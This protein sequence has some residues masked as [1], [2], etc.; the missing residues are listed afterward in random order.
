MNEYSDEDLLA[1]W[2]EFFESSGLRFKLIEV[3]DHF[4]EER[5]VYVP[6]LDLDLFDPDFADYLMQHPLKV[7]TLGKQAAKKALP[8]G[9][10]GV[11]IE[12]RIKTLPK[13]SKI[14]IRKIRSEHLGK[15]IAVEGLVRK[16]TEVR[17]KITDALFQCARCGMIIREAQEGMV[18]KE[19]ME[20]YKEQNGCGR[21]ASS[22]KFK[23]LSEESRYIDT[24]KI[25]IQENPEGL[26]GGAQPE[27][28][29]GF[30]ED[31][32][33]GAISPGDRLTLNGIIRSV[34]KGSMH[35][36]STLFDINLDVISVEFKQHEYDEVSISEEDELEILRM[37][38]DPSLFRKIVG[39]ISP[40]I[41]GYDR[42][43]EA[44]AL[45]MFGGVHKSL[46]DGTRIR[47][48][49]HVLLV[50]DP[51]V[52]KCVTG[53]T[54]VLLGDRTTRK[55]KAIV[56]EAV[57]KGPDQKVA[58]GVHAPLD[59]MV[60]SFSARGAVEPAKAVRVWKRTAPSKLLKFT[61]RYGRTLT[62]TP[63]HPFIVH[64]GSGM[65]FSPAAKI[66]V[67]QAIAVATGPGT[68]GPDEIHG[69]KR[70]LDWD[71][72]E[73]KE[74]VDAPEPFVY[75]IE[76]EDTHVFVT[77]GIL[78]HNSQ[79][80]RF[81][82]DLAPRGIYASGKSSSAAGLC[83][84]PDSIIWVDGKEIPIGEFVESNITSPMEMRPGQWAQEVDG[85]EVRSV[86]G[87]PSENKKLKAVWRINTPSFLVELVASG[88]R[89][90]VLTP[91]TRVMA[92]RFGMASAFSQAQGLMPG[93]E[94]LVR[95]N[96]EMRWVRLEQKNELR[97]DLPK[98]VYDLTVHD[99]HTFLANDFVVHNTAAAVKDD[100]GEGRWTL[101][102][103]ALVLAD[104]GLAAIDELDKMTDQDR[105][106]MHEAMESQSVSVAKAGITARLQCR[107]AILG[108]ANPKYG[109]FEESQFIADQIDLPPA[110]MSRF[111][112]IFALTD[113]PDADKDARITK[114]I[115]NVHRRG[116]IM[117][118]DE[119]K[120]IEGLEI[121][122]M[123]EETQMLEP[124]F[125]RE[126]FRKY[127]AYSKRY[128]PI[129]TD[130]AMQLISENYL[131]IRKMGEGEG[132]SVPITARQLEAYV[133]LSEASARARLSRIVTLDDAKRAVGIVEYYLRRIAGEAGRL[134]IDI[135]ATGTSKSQR[136]QIVIIRNLIK[137][138]ADR[139][140][141]I[142][143]EAL[144][145]KG[146][147]QGIPEER[148][149]T[150]LKRLS[151]NG[152][153]YSRSGGYFKLTSEG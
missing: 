9:R 152:E 141:G 40:T 56:E 14:E 98:N 50:G 92:K 89:R 64:G 113:K 94:V 133:R 13:D 72:V 120:D 99:S 123:M 69:K 143:I 67:R 82:A 91:E 79:I 39:S 66:F 129:L 20:C 148:V 85:H 146:E 83:V 116:E 119:I 101:E 124:S 45:Q 125:D 36:K 65:H 100:F 112:L 16:A 5:S 80:L 117:R 126:F 62:V 131:Q 104:M 71:T 29:A 81:M 68:C 4:P 135:I 147:E 145:Q 142:S 54:D 3:A 27:R 150:L 137:E 136:D 110:L 7:L 43:K 95:A 6:Y 51:G 17:P 34:Q 77:N 70:G 144:I 37:S 30:L 151:D 57:A 105:S 76:V 114:H 132:K 15:L 111:D 103:G 49:I 44:V 140:K 130:E 102:A 28:L 11:Q 10:E 47:G 139:D 134:D 74:E 38:K 90:L 128:N 127:I 149:R 106:S 12:L 31:D 46:D 75:D 73:S 19:P 118:S 2:E 21:T 60:M 108:A 53:D 93:D 78:S 23:L 26:R 88:D 122:R 32:L 84:G 59:L 61:T 24:Q 87:G 153:V 42:E 18:F 97:Q 138:N 22:T 41:Y 115:L 96:H 121:N 8:P 63:T 109:R 107:C 33:A 52:A 55:I 58:D 86:W 35:Q 1:R 48:D 25:E